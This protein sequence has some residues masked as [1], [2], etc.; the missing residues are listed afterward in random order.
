MEGKDHILYH[1]V[2]VR[3]KYTREVSRARD[4]QYACGIK[5]LNHGCDARHTTI[6]FMT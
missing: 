6:F 3:I 2:R 5:I 4:T 1:G